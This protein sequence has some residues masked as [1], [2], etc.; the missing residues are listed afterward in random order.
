MEC[1]LSARFV[2]G[3]WRAL[4]STPQ[5]QVHVV[6]STFAEEQTLSPRKVNCLTQ[7]HTASGGT[8]TSTQICP[9][10]FQWTSHLSSNPQCAMLQAAV[11]QHAVSTRSDGTLATSGIPITQLKCCQNRRYVYTHHH[12]F[13]FFFQAFLVSLV[14]LIRKIESVAW[15]EKEKV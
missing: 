14:P 13:L 8:I 2:Q 4:S 1:L 3:G 9:C 11:M 5:Q 7:D 12:L 15:K 6:I 10:S